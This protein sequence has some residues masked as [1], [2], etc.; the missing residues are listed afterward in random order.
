VPFEEIQAI[1]NS[2]EHPEMR[3]AVMTIIE[4]LEQRGKAKGIEEGM[5]K[6]V[7]K[8]R[9][10]G[11]VEGLTAAILKFVKLRFGPQAAEKAGVRLAATTDMAT[12]DAIQDAVAT[13]ATWDEVEAVI[14]RIAQE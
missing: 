5:E 3:S 1:F 10:E 11:R 13:A 8:G 2:T 7:Q 14:A 9:V 6:G 12:L 4:E